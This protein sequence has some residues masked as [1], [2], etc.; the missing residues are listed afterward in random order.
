M[1]SIQ[2]NWHCHWKSC[3]WMQARSLT[4]YK[5]RWWPWSFPQLDSIAYLVCDL[6]PSPFAWI[7]V[8]AI[9]E[10]W[11]NFM[12]SRIQSD[13]V[14][15]LATYG[16]LSIIAFLCFIA[17]EISDN[18]I[19]FYQYRRADANILLVTYKGVAFLRMSDRRWNPVDL[20][21]LWMDRRL[22]MAI[23]FP[24]SHYR[25]RPQS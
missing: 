23:V 18:K 11:M 13:F 14:A 8:S 3:C 10:N 22:I 20:V 24:L 6:L 19:S 25:H 21:Y 4:N 5:Y 17:C 12:G 1:N 16:S 15:Y 9:D 7:A 2:M